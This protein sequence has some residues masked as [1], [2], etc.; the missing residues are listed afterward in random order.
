MKNDQQRAASTASSKATLKD[1]LSKRDRRYYFS[2]PFANLTG[3]LLHLINRA[4][5]DMNTGS[6]K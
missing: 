5:T 6:S 4:P 3:S 2:P 1:L